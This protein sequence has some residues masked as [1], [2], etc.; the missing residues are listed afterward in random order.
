M[1]SSERRRLIE[2]GELGLQPRSF[3]DAVDKGLVLDTTEV[4]RS[5]ICRPGSECWDVKITF[6]N[7]SERL[8]Q[9][10]HV[11][12]FTVDVSDVI[13]VTVGPVR[14]WAVY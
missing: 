2:H 9:A 6:F 10:R 5:P 1:G 13:P 4:E 14:S 3:Q 7:P 8:T 11:H 12:R